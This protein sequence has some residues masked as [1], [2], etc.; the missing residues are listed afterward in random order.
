MKKIGLYVVF[1]RVTEESSPLIEAQNDR[2]AWRNYQRWLK[3]NPVNDP[4]DYDL[5]HVGF[6][7][8][9][10]LLIHCSSGKSLVLGPSAEEE[11]NHG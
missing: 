11:I 7:D 9:D 2:T 4:K 10:T 3:E 8:H 6:F 1:D 5:Y